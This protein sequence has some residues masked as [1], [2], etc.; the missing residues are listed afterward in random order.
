MC[1]S[2]GKIN[3]LAKKCP[4]IHVMIESIEVIEKYLIEFETTQKKFKRKNFHNTTSNNSRLKGFHALND[5][6]LIKEEALVHKQCLS[7]PPQN[8]KK[9]KEKDEILPEDQ[10]KRHFISLFVNQDEDFE[11]EDSKEFEPSLR[12]KIKLEIVNYPFKRLGSLYENKE[13]DYNSAPEKH[14]LRSLTIKLKENPDTLFKKKQTI[15]NDLMCLKNFDRIQNYSHY[16]PLNNFEKV[17]VKINK[18]AEA[19]LEKKKM[20]KISEEKIKKNL[21]NNVID[22]PVSS[23]VSQSNRRQHSTRKDR[24]DHLVFFPSN[25]MVPEENL[26]EEED[27]RNESNLVRINSQKNMFSPEKKNEDRDFTIFLDK[28]EGQT[29]EFHLNLKEVSHRECGRRKEPLKFENIRLK[30]SL[31]SE[32]IDQLKK[33]MQKSYEQMK[34]LFGNSY[35][36]QLLLKFENEENEE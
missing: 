8:I 33:H 2:C 9:F 6:N 16:F 30:R 11:T 21:L 36:K 23:P 14:S 35:A 19:I 28:S 10:I 29:K 27:E 26:E 22:Q 17:V 18:K 3:H 31:S 20:K 32:S 12:D 15:V 34:M 13:D 4:D 1:Y 25:E 7:I 24:K 5:F